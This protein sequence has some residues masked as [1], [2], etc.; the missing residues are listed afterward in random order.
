MGQLDLVVWCVQCGAAPQ[1]S[2]SFE[3][4]GVLGHY[5][6]CFGCAHKVVDRVLSDARSAPAR[7]PPTNVIDAEHRLRPLD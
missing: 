3:R 7:R 4:N 1:L 6:S 2:I 5:G